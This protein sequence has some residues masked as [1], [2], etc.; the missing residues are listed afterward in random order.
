MVF[1]FNVLWAGGGESGLRRWASVS[2][3]KLLQLE[4]RWLKKGPFQFR[5]GKN[6]RVY[7]F[8][9]ENESGQQRGGFAR[10][11]PPLLCLFSDPVKIAWEDEEWK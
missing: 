6:G 3:L 10:V 1:L 5:T 2:E 8:V 11:T 7:Y 4:R 9:A